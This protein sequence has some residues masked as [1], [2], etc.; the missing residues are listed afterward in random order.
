MDRIVLMLIIASA[1]KTVED[2]A[3]YDHPATFP[4]AKHVPIM[5][6]VHAKTFLDVVYSAAVGEKV[7]TYSWTT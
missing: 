6:V 2:S 4:G 3:R 5:Q 1:L 7:D